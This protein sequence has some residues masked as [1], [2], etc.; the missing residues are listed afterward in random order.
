MGKHGPARRRVVWVVARRAATFNAGRISAGHVASLENKFVE[1]GAGRRD[2]RLRLHLRSLAAKFDCD[3]AGRLSRRL[4]AWSL[5]P[6]ACSC[7]WR[8]RSGRRTNIDG[9][10]S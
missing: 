9:F 4:L 8:L 6:R 10:E 1:V 5:E 7:P 3:A 2:D